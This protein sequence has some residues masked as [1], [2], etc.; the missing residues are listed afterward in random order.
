MTVNARIAYELEVAKA[1]VASSA[2]QTTIDPT[3]FAQSI[4][5]SLADAFQDRG[6]FAEDG[7]L[8]R[9]SP[10]DTTTNNRQTVSDQ[11]NGMTR[12]QFVRRDG[13][14]NQR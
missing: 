8:V 3:D 12:V 10:P 14:Y 1:I 13:Q 5:Q 6:Y 2:T 4:A 9:Y 7:K 11:G